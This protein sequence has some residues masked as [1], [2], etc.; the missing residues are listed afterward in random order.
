[1]WSKVWNDAREG[2]LFLRRSARLWSNT[3]FSLVAQFANPVINTLTPAFLIRRFAGNDA[4]AGAVL[5]AGSEA[6]IA[7]GAVVGSAI[8]PRHRRR[9]HPCRAR[10]HVI[11]PR[12][13]STGESAGDLTCTLRGT[14]TTHGRLE[15]PLQSG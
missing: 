5:Y 11:R 13:R 4:V 12:F 3:V 10:R 14:Q 8:Q 7:L 6:A 9:V 1:T 15:E 2:F